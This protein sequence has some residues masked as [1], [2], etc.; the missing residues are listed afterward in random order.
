MNNN[1]LLMIMKK[2]LLL[3]ALS[4][5]VLAGCN[6]KPDRTAA[7][8]ATASEQTVAANRDADATE[9]P[10]PQD[11]IPVT[12]PTV[13][14]FYAT[15]CGP[16]KEL[17][18]RLEILEKKYHGQVNFIRIDVDEQPELAQAFQV[19]SIP[20]LFYI[21]PAGVVDTSLGLVPEAEIE[22][23]IASMLGKNR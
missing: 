4:A 14:D 15:W 17:A 22:E 20:M 23:K 2:I 11:L 21:T 10:I 19:E 7:K 5:V 6:K 9:T 16:C 13:V 8:D 12:G 3:V 1:Q 18:P